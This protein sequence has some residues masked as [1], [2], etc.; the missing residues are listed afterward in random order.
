MQEHSCLPH[1]QF[2][3]FLSWMYEFE[4]KLWIKIN[5]FINI[6][7]LVC[8][9]QVTINQ[10]WTLCLI[11][12]PTGYCSK[13]PMV[14]YIKIMIRR[15]QNV[16]PCSD[17]CTCGWSLLW[18]SLRVPGFLPHFSGQISW[19]TAKFLIFQRFKIN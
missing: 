15:V 18:A 19:T 13:S 9:H 5:V 2:F 10:L 12:L 3:S 17:F 16:R 4:L 7:S 14:I 6:S 11:Y 1:G 8:W